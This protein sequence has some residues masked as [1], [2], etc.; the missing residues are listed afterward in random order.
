MGGLRPTTEHDHAAPGRH[1]AMQ[2]RVTPAGLLLFGMWA[3]GLTAVFGVAQP[4][5]PPVP[6]A[7]PGSTTPVELRGAE[8]HVFRS[9]VGAEPLRIHVFKPDGWSAEDR[10]P[11]L[12]HFFGGGFVRGSPRNAAG[13]ARTAAGWGMVGIAPD[14]RTRERFGT[15]ATACVADARAALR[16]V[17]EHAA[18]LGIDPDRIVVSGSS[19]GGHLALWTAIRRAPPGSDVALSPR[20]PPA[21]VVLFSAASDTSAGLGE[22]AD[23]FGGHGDA[24]SPVH[25]LDPAMPPVLAFHGD[26]DEVVP[27]AYA[28]ALD[29]ALRARGTVAELITVPGGGH[30]L[31]S[32]PGWREKV[33]QHVADFLVQQWLLPIAPGTG[34]APEREQVIASADELKA[35][36]PRLEPG[37]T[38]VMRDGIWRDA[39]LVFRGEGSP[40]E[41]ITLRAQTPGRVVLTGASRLRLAGR[42]LV[43]DG[44]FFQGCS[45]Q[46]GQAVV[47]FREGDDRVAIRCRL[48]NSAIVDCNPADPLTDYKWVS[49]Y[50]AHNRVD[51]CRFEGKNHQGTL[52][53]VWLD[54]Q[55]NGHR[56]DRNYFGPRPPHDRNG[57]ETIRVG[58]SDWSQTISGT[59]VEDNVFHRCD[60]EQE[61][62]S[63]KSWGNAYRR[64][65]FIE[66]QGALTLRHGN[67]CLVEDNWFLG[68]GRASTGGVRIIGEDH[69]VLHNHFEGLT[70]DR[71]YAA[72]SMV[73]G[74][75]GSPLNGY[76]Q[77]RRAEVVGNTFVDTARAFSLGV[78]E[79]RP[80]AVLPPVDCVIRDNLLRVADADFYDAP[81]E[82]PGL[83]VAGN[84]VLLPLER[85]LPTGFHLRPLQAER[86]S[87]GVTRL[88]TE[89]S[90]SHAGPIGIPLDPADVGPSWR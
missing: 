42:H 53:V 33:T 41:P 43:V 67:A 52:L 71:F 68:R 12:I 85:P 10:R 74:I 39:D 15:D 24:C 80:E 38:V 59:I 30:N 11:A 78:M 28:T 34:S 48:T 83:E 45:L 3:L 79:G 70:G 55:P 62:I 50:G 89:D 23:R 21:A 20:R 36:L 6:P 72:L 26:A 14:Y 25:H 4:A 82:L 57:A 69:R 5:A 58:T 13:W 75:P 76:F 61:I 9:D 65:T 81:V 73:L 77:V 64:N 90:A 2:P 18:R 35:L 47:A 19:A 63:S 86:G 44:L 22:R 46:R 29:A 66:C 16:W 27:Y 17:Q 60:G 88:R 54:G 56:I 1:R 87:G 40:R 51:H 31:A 32:T 37:D 84:S 49:L 8:T 7:A